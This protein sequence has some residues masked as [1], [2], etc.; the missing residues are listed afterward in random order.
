MFPY[1]KETANVIEFTN[2]SGSATSERRKLK[3]KNEII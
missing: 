2:G 3:V 1:G